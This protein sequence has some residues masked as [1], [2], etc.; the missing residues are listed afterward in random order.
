MARPYVRPRSHPR[1]RQPTRQAA[2]RAVLGSD[3]LDTQGMNAAMDQALLGHYPAKAAIDAALWDLRGQILAKPVSELL[4]G[5]L[6]QRFSVFSPIPLAFPADMA[7][8][9]RTLQDEEQRCFQLK[10]GE[11]PVDDSRRAAAVYEE[12]GAS[13]ANFITC[14]ANRGC[15]RRYPPD[16]H[17][18]RRTISDFGTDCRPFGKGDRS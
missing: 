4:G 15:W 18:R 16:R 1:R 7:A 17:R 10:L 13:G 6:L 3:V 11:D 2:A 12:A 14:D 5:L 8:E 9:A